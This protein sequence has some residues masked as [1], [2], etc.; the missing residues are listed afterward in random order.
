MIPRLEVA[1]IV[2]GSALS[3]KLVGADIYS[4]F[5]LVAVVTLIIVEPALDFVYAFH[6]K[7]HL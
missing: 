3:A 5:V 1:L 4:A 6:P 7:R 2:M